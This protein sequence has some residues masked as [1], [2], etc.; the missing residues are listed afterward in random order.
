[1]DNKFCVIMPYNKNA[2]Y[3]EYLTPE[4]PVI[5]DKS[6]LSQLIEYQLE[7]GLEKVVDIRE[8][9]GQIKQG[10][11]VYYKT[12]TYWNPSGEYEGYRALIEVIK[13]DFPIVTSIGL[14]ECDI[15]PDQ[16]FHGSLRGKSGWIKIY[17]NCCEPS[18]LMIKGYYV[19]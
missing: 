15:T 17:L 11:T 6:R 18:I 12:D 7:N 9:I 19:G 1:M 10:E 3:P 14:E 2:I 8:L 5:R 4:I 13:E 16:K